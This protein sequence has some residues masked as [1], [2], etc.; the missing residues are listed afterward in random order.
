MGFSGKSETFL[1]GWM[2]AALR[3][4][5]SRFLHENTETLIVD[6]GDVAYLVD[7]P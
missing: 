1:K 7:A 6:V 3:E 2:R 5:K 4:K